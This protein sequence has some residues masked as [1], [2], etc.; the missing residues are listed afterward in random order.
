[1]GRGLMCLNLYKVLALPTRLSWRIPVSLRLIRGFF[2]ILLIP[3]KPVRVLSKICSLRL[4]C[5]A[6]ALILVRATVEDTGVE[7]I[8]GLAIV[9][10]CLGPFT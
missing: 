6:F 9:P 5:A 7:A 10:A 1:M 3:E 8:F 4:R 2:F